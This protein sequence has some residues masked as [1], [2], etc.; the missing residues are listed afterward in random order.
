MDLGPPGRLQ[1]MDRSTRGARGGSRRSHGASSRRLI[2]AAASLILFVAGALALRASIVHAGSAP[3]SEP[4][5]QREKLLG[6]DVEEA[7]GVEAHFGSSAAL[8]SDGSTLVVGAPGD[9]KARGAAWVFTR[10][11]ETWTLQGGGKLTPGELPASAGGEACTGTPGGCEECAEEPKASPAE[12]GECAFGAS[13]AVSADGNTA[14]VGNPTTSSSPGAVWVFTREGSSWTRSAELTG[15][16]TVGEGRFGKSVALSADGDTALVGDPSSTNGRGIAWLFTREGSSWTRV[17]SLEVE[18]ST[19]AHFGRS[20]ALSADGSLALIGAP[21]DDEFAGAAWTFARSGAVWTQQPEVTEEGA[22]AGDHFGKSVALSADGSTALIGAP[23]AEGERGS[24]SPFT[25]SAEGLVAQGTKFVGPE[26]ELHFGASVALSGDGDFALVGSPRATASGGTVS[27]LA[28]SESTWIRKDELLSGAGARSKSVFGA[29]VALSSDGKVAAVGSPRDS[30]RLGAAWVFVEGPPPP[31]VIEGVVPRSGSTAGGEAVTIKGEN[32]GEV[33]SVTFGGA[34]AESA[35]SIS[36]TE[37]A[38]VTPPGAPGKVEV[39]VK[40]PG[41]L[42]SSKGAF[43]Y[44]GPSDP[45]GGGGGGGGASVTSSGAR[46]SGGVAGSISA[47][48]AACSVSLG[49]KRLAV[50]RYRTVALRLTRTGAG[51]CRGKLAISYRVKAKGRGY[52]LRTIGTAS[53]SIAVGQSKVVVVKLTKAGQKWFRSH[54]G[55]ANA[56]VAIARIVPAPMTAR[57]AS[58]RLS[59]KK[60]P[61]RS[62]AK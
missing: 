47:S 40:T 38:A 15:G 20:V 49:K 12:E 5:I 45:P 10:E 29:A 9:D 54:R 26:G 28:R 4:L 27:E 57:A 48:D 61:K 46:A 36:A 2:F 51:A 44:E 13:V 19:F 16:N 34:A 30:G 56:S 8:S 11:G 58:V 35:S 31:P 22:K 24:A 14:I 52:T 17:G 59:S 21:G 42:F 3:R 50:T 32:L 39:T 25:V 33:E 23:E 62:V 1:A 7:A 41:G 43:L 37:I 18:A 60:T 55:K 53:F 6:G